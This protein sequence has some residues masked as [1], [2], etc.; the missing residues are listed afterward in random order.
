[1]ESVSI[2]HQVCTAVVFACESVWNLE[3]LYRKFRDLYIFQVVR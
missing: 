1:M 3:T 2:Q